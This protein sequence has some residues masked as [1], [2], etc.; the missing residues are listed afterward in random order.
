MIM[1]KGLSLILGLLLFSSCVGK[2]DS[3]IK[4]INNTSKLKLGDNIPSFSGYTENGNYFSIISLNRKAL[5]LFFNNDESCLLNDEISINNIGGLAQKKD[6]DILFISEMK[7][8][9]V[10][11]IEYTKHPEKKMKHS[12]LFIIDSQKRIEKI[13]RDVCAEDIV[14]LLSTY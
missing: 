12:F 9:D 13:F 6:I 2:K 3:N 14:N 4:E 1:N 5:F 7:I 8:A 11:G 10:Y